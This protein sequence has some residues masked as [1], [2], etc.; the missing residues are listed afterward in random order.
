MQQYGAVPRKGPALLQST[1]RRSIH[2]AVAGLATVAVI[3]AT[4]SYSS[5]NTTPVALASGS[6]LSQ[7]EGQFAVTFKL[8]TC[9][10]RRS[11]LPR[12]ERNILSC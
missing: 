8:T 2:V 11:N 4:M 12:P 10:H 9:H 1:R 3:A 6:W 5:V 7:I